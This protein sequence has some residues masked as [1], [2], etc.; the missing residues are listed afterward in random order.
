MVLSQISLKYLVEVSTGSV[1]AKVEVKSKT[2]TEGILDIQ[3]LKTCYSS[4]ANVMV[5]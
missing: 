2:M 1:G 5:N 4:S 3:I